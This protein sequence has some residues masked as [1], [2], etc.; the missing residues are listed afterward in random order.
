ML[1]EPLILGGVGMAFTASVWVPSF[2]RFIRESYL[3]CALFGPAT[4]PHP[5]IDH[6]YAKAVTPDQLIAATCINSFAKNFDDWVLKQ[7]LP[8]EKTRRL[9]SSDYGK[10]PD[11]FDL[12]DLTSYS[13]SSKIRGNE[14]EIKFY[15][16][17]RNARSRRTFLQTAATVNGTALSLKDSENIVSS[18]AS[19]REKY[20][21][22]KREAEAVKRKMEEEKKKWDFAENL[23]GLKRLS[24]GAL[25][26]KE[27][28]EQRCDLDYIGVAGHLPESPCNCNE[29]K[30]ND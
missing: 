4:R 9:A 1:I 17:W 7:R 15:V 2:H 26:P 23:L 14:I 6:P 13:L 8:T 19:L 16:D 22:V 27:Y 20:I 29:E 3:A 25:V 28:E 30:S 11:N 18:Y 5:I 12:M 10:V 21:A 24:S